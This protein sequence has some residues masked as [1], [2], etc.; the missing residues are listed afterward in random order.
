MEGQSGLSE[1]KHGIAWL[2]RVPIETVVEVGLL[3]QSVV[4]MRRCPKRK[5]AECAQLRSEVIQKI[6]EAKDEFCH[7]PHQYENI[8]NILY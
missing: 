4:V 7:S 1:W 5:E 2:N 8:S 6:L 3:H